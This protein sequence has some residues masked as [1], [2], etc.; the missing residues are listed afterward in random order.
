VLEASATAAVGFRALDSGLVRQLARIWDAWTSKPSWEKRGQNKWYDDPAVK[1]ALELR[2]GDK[3]PRFIRR[4]KRKELREHR[5]LN[6]LAGCLLV[7]T[8]QRRHQIRKGWVYIRRRAMG[9][10]Q[11]KNEKEE[12]I[13]DLIRDAAVNFDFSPVFSGDPLQAQKVAE[14]FVAQLYR[15]AEQDQSGAD[16]TRDDLSRRVNQLWPHWFRAIN[17][18][19]NRLKTAV[20]VTGV[21]TKRSEKPVEKPLTVPDSGPP[22]ASP[23]PLGGKTRPGE[24][25][26]G[27]QK[28]AKRVGGK[29]KK[30]KKL[31]DDVNL[32]DRVTA[33]IEED[34]RLTDTSIK[35]VYIFD[36]DDTLIR[37]PHKDPGRADYEK[38]TGK[39]WPY[40]RWWTVPE[41]LLPPFKI[42]AKPGVKGAYLRAKQDPHAKV[43]IMTGR[44]NTPGMRKAVLSALK[45]AGYP[46]HKHGD[47]L[48][49]K[50]PNTR[51]TSGWKRKVLRGLMRRWPSV[52]S[53][54]MWDDRGE[55]VEHFK[56]QIHALGRRANV[57]HVTERY[58][59]RKGPRYPVLNKGRKRLTPDERQLCMDRKAVWHHGPQG[60]ETPAVWKSEVN[61][62][63][64]YVTN[65]HRA[66]NVTPTIKGTI[67]RFHDFIKGTA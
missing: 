44:I 31:G 36:M 51:D 52:T 29:Q 11:P 21:A 64:W 1:E 41:S 25:V 67:K 34:L 39:P 27:K 60:Q 61:G 35:T 12:A 14:D 59:G 50:N 57:V 46:R 2:S 18:L 10:P 9:P 13:D 63:T 3:V 43:I 19:R 48:F 16:L 40:E 24:K 58:D 30:G 17:K 49:L 15:Y 5:A 32:F 54:H 37:Q 33:R 38:L 20:K 7:E 22:R 26:G 66:Y 62:K 65:T 6:V 28:P 42:T 4:L 8:L 23:R 45:A 53:I 55:H 47:D 56:K